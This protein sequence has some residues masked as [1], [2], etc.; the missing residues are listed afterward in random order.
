MMNSTH[1][2]APHDKILT[3]LVL[4]AVS[5]VQIFS[6]AP[7]SETQ[8]IY[9]FPLGREIKFH[10]PAKQRVGVLRHANQK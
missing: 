6:P 7:C 8:S 1:Y 9:I 2:E 4:F 3:I 10:T 5:W